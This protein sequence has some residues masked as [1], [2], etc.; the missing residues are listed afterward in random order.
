MFQ[1]LDE[2]P[3]RESSH[4][5]DLL[6]IACHLSKELLGAGLAVKEDLALDLAHGLALGEH[7]HQR[8]FACALETASCWPNQ[9]ATAIKETPD[10][11]K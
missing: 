8:G 5:T 9:H 4:A 11:T 10:D 7:V 3:I 1:T 2:D 6:D